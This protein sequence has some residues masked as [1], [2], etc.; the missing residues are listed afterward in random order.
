M[1]LDKNTLKPEQ[2]EKIAGRKDVE[3]EIRK[4]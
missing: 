4:N 3:A 2:I 1:D